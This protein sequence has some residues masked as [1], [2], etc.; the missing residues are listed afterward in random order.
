MAKKNERIAVIGA[1]AAGL[2]AAYVLSRDYR[3]TLYEQHEHAGG[4]VHT[5][6]VPEGPQVSTPIDT[7]FMIYHERGYPLFS[8]LLKQLGVEGQ[9]TDMSFS[10]SNLK[11]SSCYKSRFFA[12]L[13]ADSGQWIQPAFYKFLFDAHNFREKM[14]HDFQIGK[15]K[16]VSAEEY[17]LKLGL[18]KALLDQYVSPMRAAVWMMPQ[19]EMKDYPAEVFVRFLLRYG[20]VGPR[21]NEYWKSIPGGSFTYVQAILQKFE[22]EFRKKIEIASIRRTNE[23]VLVKERYGFENLFDYV[24]IAAHADDALKLIE[25]PT[26]DERRLLEIWRYTKSRVVLHMDE[27]L[28]PLKHSSW[29]GWNCT[30]AAEDPGRA[31]LTCFMN[32]LQKLKSKYRY[33]VTFN[34]VQPIKRDLIIKEMEFSHPVF[35]FECLRLQSELRKLN[36]SNGRTFFCGSYMGAGFHEDAVHSAMEAINPFCVS[37]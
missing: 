35:S 3:V 37:L 9:K 33:F 6:Q 21:R 16:S 24:V 34:P 11:Y 1:G 36:D 13:C 26:A 4:H 8:R 15:L 18:S 2:A 10:F 28:M 25:D 5:V 14:V 20:L 29:A 30:T 19:D 27:S 23:R 12:S 22:G 31:S 7:A 17:F 32:R